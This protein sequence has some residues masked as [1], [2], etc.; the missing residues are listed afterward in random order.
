MEL[1][2]AVS[3]L[4]PLALAV[5][6]C[7]SVALRLAVTLRLCVWLGVLLR[8][9]LRLW[10]CDLDCERVPL[11]VVLCVDDC[12][13]VC[14]CV[15]ERVRAPE[16]VAVSEG[17]LVLDAVCVTLNV[18]AALRVLVSDRDD[19]MLAL[20]G[21]GES[22]WEGERVKVADTDVVKLCDGVCDLDGVAVPLRVRVLE[23][24][25]VRDAVEVPLRV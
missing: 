22:V 11:C 14:D 7:E 17:V 3:L 18:R 9:M 13:R 10:D 12:D 1:S 16:R 21:A 15:C 6:L 8:V 20:G 2:D 23:R 19:V 5:P 4:V 24:V 25:P